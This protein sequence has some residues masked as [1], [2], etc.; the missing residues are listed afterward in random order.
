MRLSNMQPVSVV[1]WEWQDCEELKSK[2]K[3]MWIIEGKKRSKETSD[4]VVC[5]CK[6]I[7][8]HEMRKK[9]YHRNM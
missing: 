3:E 5:G 7:P 4:G 8:L 6:Q 1:W 2:P 9:Q